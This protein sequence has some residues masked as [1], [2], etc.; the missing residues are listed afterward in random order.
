[1]TVAY[2]LRAML[3]FFLL[4][5]MKQFS[6]VAYCMQHLWVV[7]CFLLRKVVF[8]YVMFFY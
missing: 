5:F 7:C 8:S 3:R 1:M 4:R 2:V 6:D